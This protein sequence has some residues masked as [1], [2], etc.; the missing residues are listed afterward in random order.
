MTTTLWIARRLP[1]TL[2]ATFL[3]ACAGGPPA[4]D[5]QMN[6]QSALER[7]SAAYMEGNA[8]VEAQ[9]FARARE[10]IARTGKLDLLARAELL[11]CAARVA[12]LVFDDC[13]G[14]APADAAP[15]EG[16]YARYLAGRAQAQDIALLPAPQRA[17]A[18][19]GSDTAAA[20]AIDG[21]ADPL[22]KLVAAG[23]LLRT[24]RATPALFDR[25]VN[26]AS[27]QGWRRPL[28]AWLGVQATRAEQAGQIQQAQQLRRRI[29]L[30]G[31]AAPR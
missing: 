29:A 1:A 23:V 26:T 28:L 24:G 14:F 17:V 12:S 10:Q 15:A 2:L 30:A 6:A 13:A 3:A 19:A 4:P 18:G 9:E 25:A 20:A 16:A 21:I 7:A 8:A 27:D 11:R 31:G 22:S 5:W